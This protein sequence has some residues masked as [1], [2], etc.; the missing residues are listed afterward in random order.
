MEECVV[1]E[2]G[3]VDSRRRVLEQHEVAHLIMHKLN[4]AKQLAATKELNSCQ[5]HHQPR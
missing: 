3:A 2:L 1:R 5:A 4:K